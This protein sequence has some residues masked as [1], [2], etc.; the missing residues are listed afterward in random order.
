MRP[1][2]R[3]Y[4]YN[5]NTASTRECES[6][7]REIQQ[8]PPLGPHSSCHTTTFLRAIFL[9]RIHSSTSPVSQRFVL[10]FAASARCRSAPYPLPTPCLCPVAQQ[11]QQKCT[12]YLCRSSFVGG[13]ATAANAILVVRQHG[14][15][16]FV[17]IFFSFKFY[18]TYMNFNVFIH[19]ALLAFRAT[20]K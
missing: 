14:F 11:R 3:K 1:P 15:I 6:G 13:G 9:H 20:T 7:A 8:P 4:V 18:H 16:P 19:V 2:M 17:F 10:L 5:E 12:T